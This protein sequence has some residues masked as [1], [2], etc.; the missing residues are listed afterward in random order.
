MGVVDRQSDLHEYQ[1]ICLSYEKNFVLNVL[2][3]KFQDIWHTRI[4][5]VC[6]TLSKKSP[7][8]RDVLPITQRTVA[9]SENLW[10]L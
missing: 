3:K 8:V 2:L 6:A 1:E 10:T 9:I 5:L 4:W 7:D